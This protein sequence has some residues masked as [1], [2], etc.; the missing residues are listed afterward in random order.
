M[1][2]LR[3]R[4]GELTW[5]RALAVIATF[6]AVLRLVLLARQPLGYDEDF[7]AAVVAKPLGEMLAAVG[8]DSAPPLFYVAEWLVAQFWQGPAGL[9]LVP[10]IAGVALIP[11]L[12]V[13]ARRGASA[14]GGAGDAAGLWAGALA[15][16]LPATL[17]Y[18]ENAR[19]YAAA[20]V[21]VVAATLLLWRAIE[22]PG[23]WRWIGYGVAAAAAVWTDYFA[24]VAL[25]GV[26]VAAAWLRPTRRALVLAVA[27]TAVACASL[28]PWLVAA[29]D[30]FAHA[31]SGFWVQPLGLESV[32]GT[33]GQLFAGP[34]VDPGIKG[35][36]VLIGLQVV[37]VVAG[38]LALAAV[39]FVWRHRP[40]SR[41]PIAF[42]LVACSGVVGLAIVSVWRPLL[43]ARYAEVMWLPLFALAGAGLAAL[44]R[45]LAAALIV[46]VA[47]PALALGATITHPETASLL[48]G[49]EAQLGRHD[50]VAADADHYLAVLDAGDDQV[51]AQLHLLA[52]VDPPWYFGTAAYPAGGVIHAVP[53]DVVANR[54]SIFWVAGPEATPPTLPAGYRVL[55]RRCAALVC[56]TVYGPAGG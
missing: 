15:A 43:E 13:L 55:D 52:D 29:R 11:L 6:G 40:E 22:R 44:P 17:L 39:A 23:L 49:I 19:M 50:L 47:V 46:A 34:P 41:R 4:C 45:R 56:V 1:I 27:V 37:A 12:A 7:T 25:L 20:G 26:L 10:A 24:A 31:G 48:P 21:L 42:L 51:R 8:R 38:S 18:S 9:R 30:Q 16:V 54:G 32:A 3:G 28:T 53:V 35:R 2:S 33:V 36:E 5:G 14:A